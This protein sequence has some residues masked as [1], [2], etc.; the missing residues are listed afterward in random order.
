MTAKD[1]QRKP[2][3]EM[4]EQELDREIEECVRLLTGEEKVNFICR[5]LELEAHQSSNTEKECKNQ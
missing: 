5:L 1:V 2:I 4:T 3:E